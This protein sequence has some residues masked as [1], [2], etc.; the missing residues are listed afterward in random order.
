MINRDEIEQ[1]S[2]VAALIPCCDIMISE[3][4][5]EREREKRRNL[6]EEIAENFLF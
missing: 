3:R 1:G 6:S 4:E 2:N 5:I